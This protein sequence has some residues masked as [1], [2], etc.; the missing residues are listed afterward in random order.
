[1]RGAGG[2]DGFTIKPGV[3]IVEQYRNMRD[4]LE[5]NPKVLELAREAIRA[6]GHTPVEGRIRGGTDGSILSEMGLP[7]PNLS[8]GQHAFHSRL[9]WAS[10]QE[11]EAAV[12]V[13]VTLAQLWEQ[14]G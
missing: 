11:M 8:S 6:N 3:E 10:V 9:E 14:K 2:H 5:R 7:T 1:M 4:V 13:V 12:N